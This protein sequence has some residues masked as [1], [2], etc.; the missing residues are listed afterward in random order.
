MRIQLFGVGTQSESRAI[1]AQRRLNCQVEV[2][3]EQDRTAFAL[4]SRP[5]LKLYL[6]TLSGSPS[7]G[8][9]AVNTLSAPLFFTVHNNTLYSVNNAMVI[10]NIGTITGGTG[11]VSMADD[12]TWLVIVDGTNGWTYNMITPAGLN[13]ITDGN[14]TT[15]PRTV[16]WQDNYFCVTSSG[17]TKQFQFSQ[18]SPSIDP[19]TWPAA[20]IGFGSSG[21][22][23][24]QNGFAYHNI[25]NLFGD[26][27][28][29]FWQDTGSPD[30]PYALIPGSAQGYGLAAPFSLQ[31]FDNSLA[32]LF[33][34]GEGGVNVSRLSGFSLRKV[35]D[36]DMDEILSGYSAVSDGIGLSFNYSG[37]PMYVINL[38]SAGKTWM[39]DGYANVWSELQ[40][41]TG[42]YWGTYTCNFLGTQ[43]VSD[44]NNGNIYQLDAN[45]FSDNG[46]AIPMEVVSKHIWNDDKYVGIKHIQIDIESGVGTTTGQGSNPVC[47]LQVSKDGGA[48]F[49]SVGFSSMGAL[50]NYTTRLTWNNLGAARD[51]VL[52]LRIT[53]PVKRVITG[54]SAEIAGSGF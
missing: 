20:Q 23:A 38:P 22:G 21:G 18:I 16:T 47:D 35:S 51:W 6:T 12:G 31:S 14:F 3:R 44:Y 24:L 10:N 15:T 28:A 17:S 32:G 43:L 34:S 1:T 46:T 54:A 30:L 13:Q 39:Y 27:Y 49:Y 41:G 50:G 36:H 48:S 19:T 8:M 7:R 9:H 11:T 37:H 5:G 45:T 33:K 29:E 4:T 42:R 26:T 53:D 52:K 40:S 2:R 25:L